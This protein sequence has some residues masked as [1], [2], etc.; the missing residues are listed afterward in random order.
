LPK[1]FGYFAFVVLFVIPSRASE[2]AF[3]RFSPIA[4]KAL[5]ASTN[6]AFSVLPDTVPGNTNKERE[7]AGSLALLGMTSQ[8]SK[9]KKQEQW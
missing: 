3:S 2:P 4:P 5:C 8:K 9:N 7:K 1:T 6:H